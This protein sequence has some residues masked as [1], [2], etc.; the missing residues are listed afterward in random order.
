MPTLYNDC[1][2]I[3]ISN[4]K[5]WEY[6]NPNE[7]KSGVIT[8]SRNGNTLASIRIILNMNPESPVLQLDYLY[9]DTPVNYKVELVSIPSNLG[10]GVVWYFLCPVTGKRCRKLY[11]VG[12]YFYHR[13]AFK[14]CLYENQTY[15]HRI[16]RMRNSF[17]L[18]FLI[19]DINEQIYS[20]H[21]KQHYRGQPTKRYSK[22]I[23]RIE[24]RQMFSVKDLF[25]W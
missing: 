15:S 3:S 12:G 24:A 2:T 17:D 8:W 7:S 19:D 18:A 22:L 16:R 10:Q 14:G 5:R 25:N 4:L 13:S 6:L 9:N 21:F 20:K 23:N 11:L 1:H